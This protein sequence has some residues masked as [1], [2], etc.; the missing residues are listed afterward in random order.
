VKESA[1][2]FTGYRINPVDQQFRFVANQS[3]PSIKVFMKKAGPWNGDQ[4]IDIILEQPQCARFVVTKIWRSFVYED[5]D[6]SLVDELAG[7]FR[8]AHYEIKPLLRTI[9]SSEEF[10]S[11]RA[12]GA[13]IKSPVQYLVQARR[14]LG[15][16]APEGRALANIYRQLG[17]VPFY[18]P[19]VKGWDG[20]KSWINTGTLTCRYQIARALISGIR[21]EQAGLPKFPPKTAA[22]TGPEL[23]RQNAVASMPSNLDVGTPPATPL[24]PLTSP[25]PVEKYVNTEDRS[26]VQRLLGKLYTQIFQSR[27]QP[28]LL[29]NF[30]EVASNKSLPLD[31]GSIRDLVMLMMTTPNYQVS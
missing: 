29:K 7:K 1:K 4:I 8:Q 15:V 24:P 26:D 17:Q 3:D 28:D 20:G 21:P 12:K 13:I 5:P 14:S 18:P 31:D 11:D 2:A 10:Y 22:S 19:N 9:F 23:P 30:I 27:P 6:A 16:Y 25:W